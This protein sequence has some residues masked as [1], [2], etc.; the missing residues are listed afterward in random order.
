[1]LASRAP[2]WC[3]VRSLRTCDKFQKQS[4]TDRLGL[5]RSPSSHQ[6]SKSQLFHVSAIVERS[7][8]VRGSKCGNRDIFELRRVQDTMNKVMGVRGPHKKVAY[9]PSLRPT[10]A[11]SAIGKHDFKTI[12]GRA[13][14]EEERGSQRLGVAST[15]G[16]VKRARQ[17]SDVMF[18][19][20]A[21]MVHSGSV[22]PIFQKYKIEIVKVRMLP[23]MRNVHVFW[24]TT[25]NAQVDLEIEEK[26]RNEAGWLIRSEMSQLKIMGR[27]PQVTFIADDTRIRHN[28][29]AH[30]IEISDKPPEDD[31]D[32]LANGE[33]KMRNFESTTDI[34]E[35]GLDLSRRMTE[36]SFAADAPTWSD[37]KDGVVVVRDSRNLDY[38]RVMNQVIAARVA[39]N[40]SLGEE[41][42]RQLG[43]EVA[44]ESKAGGSWRFNSHN[45]DELSSYLKKRKRTLERR[46]INVGDE[47]DDDDD[48]TDDD[49]EDFSDN[50][51]SKDW[52]D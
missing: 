47:L 15:S 14:D 1:M 46:K 27:F 21:E 2:T 51:R 37:M 9:K 30:I 10:S 4:V 18:L 40:P 29:V 26:L 7:N 22:H 49:L 28:Q 13:F 12:K 6:T 32:A 11:A 19:R 23:D 39:A 33:S 43:K 20:I 45:K 38:D 35:V 31:N 48:Y 34:D 17:L 25:G 36:F 16:S 41:W 5:L 42:N 52:D 24:A 8:A 3:L 44:P 50:E